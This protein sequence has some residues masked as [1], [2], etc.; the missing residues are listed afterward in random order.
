MIKRANEIGFDCEA[1]VQRLRQVLGERPE[2]L[3]LDYA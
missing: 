1:S 2:R 3:R